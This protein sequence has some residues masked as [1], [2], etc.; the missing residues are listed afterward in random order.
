MR[1]EE[2]IRNS[3]NFLELEYGFKYEV[4]KDRGVTYT[5]INKYGKFEY[6][7]W[8]QFDESRFI[9][10][11]K[12]ESRIINMFHESP[13]KIGN[14]NFE[15]KGF[16]GLLKDSRQEYW[17][18]IA[19]IIKNNISETGSLFGLRIDKTDRLANFQ[20]VKTK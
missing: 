11:Y 4:S 18:I 6:Y 10:Y 15:S 12:G 5:Y 14:F 8:Q 9:I 1:L 7:Q 2:I 16:K 17:K 20:R 13:K 19:E 3:L